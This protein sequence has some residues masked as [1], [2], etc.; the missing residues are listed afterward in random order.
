MKM[1]KIMNKYFICKM[2]L[3]I[4][5]YTDDLKISLLLVFIFV[6]VILGLFSFL[7]LTNVWLI[8]I[9]FFSL[10]GLIFYIFYANWIVYKFD[11]CLNLFE[12]VIVFIKTLDIRV[13]LFIFFLAFLFLVIC[14]DL[15]SQAISF[16]LIDV[17]ISYGFNFFAFFLKLRRL[18]W[19]VLSKFTLSMFSIIRSNSRVSSTFKNYPTSCGREEQG[20]NYWKF[21][22]S[23]PGVN[24]ERKH[25]KSIIVS[26]EFRKDFDDMEER[27]GFESKLFI[28]QYVGRFWE[29]NFGDCN[30]V[31]KKKLLFQRF[32]KDSMK[33]VDEHPGS[34]VHFSL[35]SPLFG[36]IPH[37][38]YPNKSI[39]EFNLTTLKFDKISVK[40]QI[41]PNVMSYKNG[42]PQQF[43]GNIIKLF[44]VK[45]RIELNETLV[46]GSESD[47]G[48]NLSVFKAS[49]EFSEF[50]I[51]RNEILRP[52]LKN[53]HNSD[54]LKKIQEIA[55]FAKQKYD[56]TF[57]DCTYMGGFGESSGVII[58][59]D[60]K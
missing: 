7:V 12:N 20:D 45:D 51:S 23:V 31:F 47:L 41:F 16:D 54:D 30:G 36:M 52:L 15:I 60:K 6:N 17:L 39:I 25:I 33:V 4:K 14:L 53:I 27:N 13:Y 8:A 3:Y 29:N 49:P 5:K 28:D 24:S 58:N 37:A 22:S 26:N 38:T 18:P 40:P 46:R 1:V 56:I 57:V 11:S 34:L 19:S 59:V 42:A 10:F 35:N 32:I 21:K 2:G 55:I 9:P 44:Y 50:L 48:L 43:F